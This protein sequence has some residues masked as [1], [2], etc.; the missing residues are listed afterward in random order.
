MRSDY[1]INDAVVNQPQISEWDY[2]KNMALGL[3][4][5]ELMKGSNKDAWWV[6]DKGHSYR[7]RIKSRISHDYAC[8]MCAGRQAI[9]GETDLF[10]TNPELKTE[11]DFDKNTELDPY[12]LMANSKK[13]VW[14]K[15]A[16][17][18][19]W[20]TS[21][22]SRA[23]HS[24]S[25][26]QCKVTDIG[27]ERVPLSVTHPHLLAEWDYKKN[28]ALGISP[29]SIT[30]GSAKKAWWKCSKGHEWSA[31]ISNRARQHRQCPYCTKQ[32]PIVGENDLLTTHPELAKEWDFEKN[33]NI[34]M[35]ELF[36]GSHKEVWWKCLTC[37]HSY[38][39]RVD[40]RTVSTVGQYCPLCNNRVLVVGKNDL[41]TKCPELL[42]EWMY[43][44]NTELGLD[45]TKILYGDRTHAWWK[46]KTCGGEWKTEIRAR[47]Y[48][49]A[50]CP[51]CNDDRCL[52]G[53]SDL[54]TVHPDLLKEFDYEKNEF[55]PT[56]I[57]SKS[58]IKVWWKC[59]YC[60]KSWSTSAVSRA[61]GLHTGCPQCNMNMKSS[62]PERAVYYYVHKYFDD[63][64]HSYSIEQR[65]ELDIFVPSLNIAIEYDGEA[66]HGKAQQVQNRNQVDEWKNEYCLQHGIKLIRIREPKCYALTIPCVIYTVSNRDRTELSVVIS[67][68]LHEHFNISNADVNVLRDE[69]DIVALSSNLLYEKS[70][71][72]QYPEIA[73]RWHPSK[74]GELTA[75][76]VTTYSNTKVWWQCDVCKNEYQ[77]PVYRQVTAQNPCPFCYKMSYQPWN[78]G[79]KGVVRKTTNTSTRVRRLAIPPQTRSLPK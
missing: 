57:A 43:D 6:C 56:Q 14:W 39:G 70:L 1:N 72:S 54:A 19:S 31:L 7:M 2:T 32:L 24:T 61:Y 3:N 23:I 16:Q 22:Q 66:W 68:M 71:Y 60:G 47:G 59:S 9:V 74:N 35:T 52:P 38:L 17:G 62:F 51:Y 36:A 4:P 33:I 25:C 75:E 21:I 48:V 30:Y 53:V 8:P 49:G 79:L 28:T 20:E 26:P 12:A 50:G 45:P 5:N 46:C 67:K 77:S 78:K 40:Y 10:T 69:P 41:A 11:W 34:K 65:R 44:K 18:H 58:D 42:E 29:T 13:K 76:M 55:S 63:A 37:G 73:K 15:C 64:I 27:K